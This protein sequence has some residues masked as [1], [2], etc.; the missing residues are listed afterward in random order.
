MSA[1]RSSLPKLHDR[2]LATALLLSEWCL[3]K[4]GLLI[5]KLWSTAFSATG[6]SGAALCESGFGVTP[7]GLCQDC[8]EFCKECD[9]IH[10]CKVCQEGFVS[11]DGLCLGCAD[12]CGNCD[13]A[14]P[15]KCD[16]CFQGFHVTQEGIC[17]L[18]ATQVAHVAHA[19]V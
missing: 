7:E 8:G 16:R 9:A 1:L 2:S 11:L 14:G 3:M 4:K 18:G 12:R 19:H 10:D 6:I 5:S 17:E 15:A 13:K